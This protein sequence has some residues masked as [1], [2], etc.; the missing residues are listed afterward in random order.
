M[1]KSIVYIDSRNIAH[2]FEK[3][4]IDP[5]NFNY[6]GW[7][8]ELVIGN[9]L[10]IRTIEAIKFFA[11][12][13]PSDVDL[14]KHNRDSILHSH[15]NSSQKI[16]VILGHFKVN[17]DNGKIRVQEKGVDVR[18]AIQLIVD[19]M[20]DKFDDAYIFSTDTDLTHAVR[21]CKI[22]FPAKRIYAF[23]DKTLIEWKN[24]T[25]KVFVI[26]KDK[27]KK[28]NNHHS[29]PASESLKALEDKFKK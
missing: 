26:F 21:E 13:Y 14:N 24:V 12:V 11:A 18:L 16:E 23:C 17:Y 29:A 19:A 1:R 10:N 5:Y 7:V 4:Q 8:E 27:A 9:K 6:R 25:D 3:Y 20:G 2:L 15:L 22:Q 28:F